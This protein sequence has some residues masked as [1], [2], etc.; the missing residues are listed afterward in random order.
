MLRISTIPT[1]ALEQRE[2]SVVIHG[3]SYT[4]QPH[5]V[6]RYVLRS[7]QDHGYWR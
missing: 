5:H 7:L 1:A 3:T 6:I 2:G 4:S